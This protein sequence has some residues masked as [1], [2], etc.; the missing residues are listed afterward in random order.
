[1][2]KKVYRLS[3]SFNQ[4]WMNKKDDI[5]DSFKRITQPFGLGW[6]VE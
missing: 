6:T 4:G 1:M 2:C 3:C 5:L